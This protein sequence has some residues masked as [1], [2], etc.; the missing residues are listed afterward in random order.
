M[1]RAEA[2]RVPQIGVFWAL[3]ISRHGWDVVA[4]SQPFDE[5]PLI[6]GFRT[7]EA[8]HIDLWPR[9]RRDTRPGV[10][11]EYE[12]HPRGRVN[13][14]EEDERFL[15]LLDPALRRPGWIARVMARF[16]L[17]SAGTLVMTDSHYHSTRKPPDGARPIAI[18]EN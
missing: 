9:I 1:T 18:E 2:S 12:D 3:P 6:G 17:P 7:M 13:W 14:R 11:G 4:V 8:G 5:V 16:A 10:M 15:L